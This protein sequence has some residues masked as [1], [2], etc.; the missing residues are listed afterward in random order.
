MAVTKA[1]WAAETTCIVHDQLIVWERREGTIQK[2]SYGREVFFDQ[3]HSKA[4]HA[5]DQ[6]LQYLIKL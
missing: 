4:I 6:S 3:Q 2:I 1:V 5:Y